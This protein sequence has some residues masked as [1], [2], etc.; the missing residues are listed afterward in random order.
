MCCC[1]GWKKH[2][3]RWQTVPCVKQP[4]GMSRAVYHGCGFMNFPCSDNND[5]ELPKVS[6]CRDNL[7]KIQH[8][9]WSVWIRCC[10]ESTSDESDF[11]WSKDFVFQQF[12]KMQS[13]HVV[14]VCM[15]QHMCFVLPSRQSLLGSNYLLNIMIG[16]KMQVLSQNHHLFDISLQWLFMIRHPFCPLEKPVAKLCNSS[17]NHPVPVQ[18][19]KLV[20]VNLLI[21]ILRSSECLMHFA[22]WNN[23]SWVISTGTLKYLIQTF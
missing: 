1:L 14:N 2:L 11:Q 12:S 21:L 7:F 18:F 5:K 6:L 20:S 9:E 8:R 17:R 16:A 3:P 13:M 15:S 19:N 10:V 23:I 4:A 22:V